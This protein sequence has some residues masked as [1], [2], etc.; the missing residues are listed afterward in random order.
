MSP[1]IVALFN[2][3]LETERVNRNS[4]A[5]PELLIGRVEGGSDVS[6]G[7]CLLPWHYTVRSY[8]IIGSCY[9]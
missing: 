3:T 6:E 9:C 2:S 8:S 1:G 7:S 5:I 4:M